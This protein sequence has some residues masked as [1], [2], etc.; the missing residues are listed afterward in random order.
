MRKLLYIFGF[1][2]F[3][4]IG[5]FTMKT[6]RFASVFSKVFRVLRPQRKRQPRRQ[7]SRFR[8]SLRHERLF[9][10]VPL[11]A[12]V[13]SAYVGEGESTGRPNRY[14]VND[15]GTLEPL[16]VLVLINSLNSI[17]PGPVDLPLGSVP[18]ANDIVLG[19]IFQSQAAQVDVVLGGY[20]DEGDCDVVTILAEDQTGIVDVTVQGSVITLK[21]DPTFS[22]LLEVEYVAQD[23]DGSDTGIIS[24]NVLPNSPP[25][26]PDLSFTT[27]VGSSFTFSMPVGDPDGQSVTV[28]LDPADPAGLGTVTDNSDGTFTYLSSVPGTDTFGYLAS[29]GIV[30]SAGTI[31]MTVVGEPPAENNSP[32]DGNPDAQYDTTQGNAVTFALGVFDPDGDF[33]RYTIEYAPQNGAL[34]TDSDGNV[35]YTPFTGFVGTDVFVIKIEDL[36]DPDGDGNFDVLSSISARRFVNVNSEGE[37]EGWSDLVDPFFAELGR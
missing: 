11:A 16:D 19:D 2:E 33:L 29:D 9:E 10:R 12:D 26:A 32:V 5:V 6:N 20:V 3:L 23:G 37:G 17:G 24:V 31:I 35:T 30:R 4:S 8:R 36:R 7:Q 22:G 18:T 1:R 34:N 15:N 13:L 28:I 14:D 21:P 27:D 25:F